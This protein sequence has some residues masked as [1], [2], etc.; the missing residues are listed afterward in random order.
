MESALFQIYMKSMSLN[1]VESKKR[2]IFLD[3]LRGFALLGVCMANYPEFSLYT[4]QPE[5]VVENMPSASLDKIVRFLMLIFID[6]KFYTL[7]SLLFGIGFSIIISNAAERG[8][9]GFKNF[10]RRMVILAFI[11]C[12]HLMLLWSGDILLLYAILGMILPLFQNVS[13]R[14]ILITAI[15]LLILPVIVDGI[16]EAT[17]TF[18][19]QYPYRKWWETAHFFGIS[20]DNFGTWLRDSSSYQGINH[21]LL[22][23]A[24]ERMYE[25][26]DGNRYF[27]VLGLFLI[28]FV[29]GRKNIYAHLDKHFHFFRKVAVWGAIIGLP[30][31]MLY[32]IDGMEEHPSGT[33]IHSLL[34]LISVYPLGFCYASLLALICTQHPDAIIW[35]WF[36]FPG[37]MALTN[38]ISQSLIGIFL[39]YGIG[40]G[41]GAYFG[42][43]STELIAIGVFSFQILFS[44]FWLSFFRFGPLEWIWR[45]LTYAKFL[46]IVK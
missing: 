1:P 6:G 35:K 4:F 5:S 14:N 28:G 21:F 34:Y 8:R 15:S 10:Y 22:Q 23:G 25:F 11:G 27:K 40:L 37:R 26:V 3:A 31:S 45:M 18:L 41:L 17:G 2:H 30:F 33:T 12:T 46:P 36:A 29:L 9:D 20:E 39:F 16:C 24:W 32:A 13:N 43:G 19:A 44:K 42:L 38:Y 7:F